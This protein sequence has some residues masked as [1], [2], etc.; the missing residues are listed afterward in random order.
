MNKEKNKKLLETEEGKLALQ[1][2]TACRHGVAYRDF[3]L[4]CNDKLMKA[5]WKRVKKIVNDIE[6]AH[7]D[8]AESTLHFP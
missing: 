1:K 6:K 8:V 7:K 3:C 4:K 2:A 5:T